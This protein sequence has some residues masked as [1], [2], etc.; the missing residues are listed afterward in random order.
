MR[1]FTVVPFTVTATDVPLRVVL[2]N[3]AVA[4]VRLAGP[5]PL[6]LTTKTEPCATGAFGNPWPILLA[7]F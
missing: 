6:P 3:A 2:G 4:V 1:A 7:A 5:R